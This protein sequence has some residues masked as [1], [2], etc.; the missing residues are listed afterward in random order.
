[1]MKYTIESFVFAVGA[2][3]FYTQETAEMLFQKGMQVARDGA[4][5]IVAFLND[6]G[7]FT[8]QRKAMMG[9]LSN[10]LR[11]GEYCVLRTAAG[12][13]IATCVMY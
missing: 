7:I 9:G 1:M 3:N 12:A 4:A 6:G 10:V 5:E 11:G 8:F 2:R 13:T